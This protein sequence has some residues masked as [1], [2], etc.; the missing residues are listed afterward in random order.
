MWSAA[1]KPDST[2]PF[3]M[4]I[5]LNV[6]GRPLG[7]EDRLTGL[8]VELDG[9][10]EQSLAVFVRKQEHRLRSVANVALDQTRLVVGDERDH[11][12]TRDVSVVHDGEA[13]GIEVEMNAVQR[14]T[15]NR[16]ADRSAV[17]HSWEPEVVGVARLAGGLS[18]SVLSLARCDQRHSACAVLAHL[19]TPLAS[20][21][22][23]A[24]TRSPFPGAITPSGNISESSRP[25][26]VP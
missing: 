13:G 2:L 26:R 17:E 18:D 25:I 20:R 7:I 12:L 23:A 16:R 24:R 21:A 22:N 8:F 19:V 5:V 3:S 9:C 6:G 4:R 11:V 1:A 10:S 14:A 15:R